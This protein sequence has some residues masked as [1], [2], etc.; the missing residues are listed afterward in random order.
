MPFVLYARQLLP[1]SW[2]DI[3]EKTH[4]PKLLRLVPWFVIQ[5]EKATVSFHYLICFIASLPITSSSS[6]TPAFH[7]WPAHHSF[8]RSLKRA[9][10]YCF[11]YFPC[12]T[13]SPI[14]PHIPQNQRN[15]MKVDDTQGRY[16]MNSGSGVIQSWIPVPTGHLPLHDLSSFCSSLSLIFLINCE[17]LTRQYTQGI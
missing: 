11:L 5:L 14:F 7:P 12:I 13:L 2:G 6:T 8:V 4:E 9:W 1:Q 3:M 15:V 16:V 17:I 10:L